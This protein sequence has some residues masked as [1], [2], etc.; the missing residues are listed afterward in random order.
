MYKF[1]GYLYLVILHI[2]AGLGLESLSVGRK[3]GVQTLVQNSAVLI[4]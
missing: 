3:P 1:S 4:V 2:E